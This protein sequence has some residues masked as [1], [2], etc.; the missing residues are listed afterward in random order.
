MIVNGRHPPVVDRA[1]PQKGVLIEGIDARTDAGKAAP[2]G[3][4]A[5][6]AEK[7]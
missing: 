4:A 1:G 2:A 6:P 3:K 5:A 7:K